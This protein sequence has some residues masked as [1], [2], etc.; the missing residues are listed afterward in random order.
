MLASA[1]S[2]CSGGPPV[3]TRTGSCDV[4]D[5]ILP[6]EADAAVISDSLVEQ[7]LVHNETGAALGCWPAPGPEVDDAGGADAAD[8]AGARVVGRAGVG[9]VG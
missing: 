8:A 7:L 5:P 9:S 3:E 1:V 2:A 4:F 6:T